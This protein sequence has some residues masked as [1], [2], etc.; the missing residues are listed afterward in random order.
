MSE[1]ATQADPELRATARGMPGVAIPKMPVMSAAVNQNNFS[2]GTDQSKFNLGTS[3]SQSSARSSVGL[4]VDRENPAIMTIVG[5]NEADIEKLLAKRYH[6]VVIPIMPYSAPAGPM[7]QVVHQQEIRGQAI[8]QQMVA[9]QHIVDQPPPGQ[10]QQISAMPIETIN[11]FMKIIV[12]GTEP[13]ADQLAAQAKPLKPFG[14]ATYIRWDPWYKRI[15]AVTSGRWQSYNNQVNTE[16]TAH[17]VVY[18][19]NTLAVTAVDVNIWKSGNPWDSKFNDATK[20]AAL[21][22]LNGLKGSPILKFPAH[23]RRSEVSFD[24]VFVTGGRAGVGL[25]APIND[26]ETI[27]GL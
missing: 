3:R 24:L 6:R 19:N 18:P 17:V 27:Y 1:T 4:K 8:A 20:Q 23:T 7:Q 11:R 22:V 14:Q 2:L 5:H 9:Q 26:V 12:P 10:W 16:V 13:S 21:E 15:Q 25:N